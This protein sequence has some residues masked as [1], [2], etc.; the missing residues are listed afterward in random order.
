MQILVLWTQWQITLN[1][2]KQIDEIWNHN[3]NK[4]EYCQDDENVNE[5]ILILNAS[6]MQVYLNLN[7]L[8]AE[9]VMNFYDT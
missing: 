9:N 1:L 5:Y 6:L 4:M 3:E 7:S 8:W 2:S